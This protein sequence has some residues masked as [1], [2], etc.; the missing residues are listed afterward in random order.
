MRLRL[1][2][3][4]LVAALSIPA[5]SAGEDVS[6]GMIG[7]DTEPSSG[8][9]A[10][11]PTTGEGSGGGSTTGD[12]TTTDPTTTDPTTTDLTS[13]GTTDEPI[14]DVGTA[15]CACDQG[16]CEDGLVCQDGVCVEGLACDPVGEPDD[17]E[18]NAQSLG[19]VT[20]DDDDTRMAD[21]VIGGLADADWYTYHALDTALHIAEP[22]VK[23]TASGSLRVC[24]FLECDEGGAVMTEVT[25]PDGT[26]FALSGALRPG[27]CGGATFT[28]SDFNC[29]G[30]S[31]DIS[32]YV[33]LDKPFDD[34]CVD[35]SLTIHN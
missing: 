30:S 25:C 33:R 34:E 10:A 4:V 28:V 9:A 14:C 26:D 2:L 35:Y 15:N 5:C 20:D 6:D 29:P 23:V 21:G 8:G 22:T 32:V 7:E 1:S 24:Q 18:P 13:G 17:D 3:T 19:E 31:D 27:C 16:M 12:P 11:A